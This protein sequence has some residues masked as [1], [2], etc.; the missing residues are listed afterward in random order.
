MDKA[1][2][3][4]QVYRDGRPHEVAIASVKTEMSTDLPA[5]N[6]GELVADAIQKAWK[7]GHDPMYFSVVISFC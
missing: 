5:E 7:D 3:T 1:I 2:V 6:L 4:A